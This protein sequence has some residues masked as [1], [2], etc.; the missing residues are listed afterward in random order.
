MTGAIVVDGAI[1]EAQSTLRLKL[2]LFVRPDFVSVVRIV[3]EYYPVI[4]LSLV[5]IEIC[6]R[7]AETKLGPLET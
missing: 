5:E 7:L 3:T 1:D 6:N 2:M 4:C